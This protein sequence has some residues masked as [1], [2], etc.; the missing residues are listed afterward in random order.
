MAASVDNLERTL[1][2]KEHKEG[3]KN[4]T[5]CPLCS[6]CPSWPNIRKQILLTN[7]L[8]VSTDLYRND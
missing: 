5:S 2:H 8:F 4:T 6:L 1:E 3:T 7:Y